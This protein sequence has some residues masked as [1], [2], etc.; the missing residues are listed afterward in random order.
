M[1]ATKKRAVR[2][3]PAS[4]GAVF[5]LIFALAAAGCSVLPQPPARADVYD[6]GPG[7]AQA[8]AAGA[9]LPAI[10]L[11]EVTT[12]GGVPEG[13]SALLYRLAERAVLEVRG[14]EVGEVGALVR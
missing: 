12:L 3:R 10:A 6:F 2:A 4:A 9:P 7:P 14:E 11:A 8:A 13:S 5:G 1:I